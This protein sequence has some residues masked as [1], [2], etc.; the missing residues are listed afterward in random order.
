MRAESETRVDMEDD[1]VQVHE[2]DDLEAQYEQLV[3]VPRIHPS[4][5]RSG[6]AAASV[7]MRILPFASFAV[8]AAAPTS[9]ATTRAGAWLGVLQQ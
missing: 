6:C 2:E 1:M 7:R 9:A 3:R 4:P 8:Q 5:A